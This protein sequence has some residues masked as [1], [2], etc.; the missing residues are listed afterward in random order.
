MPR[1]RRNF[2]YP[3]T[4]V[5]DITAAI[6]KVAAGTTNRFLFVFHAGTNDVCK[7]R[8][9]EMLEKYRRLIQQ[10]KTKSAN[11]IISGVLATISARNM[12]YIYI[13]KP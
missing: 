3:G 2:C 9:E 8:S 7:T 11:I 6:D 5:D 13:I 1:R 4:G 12:L 10:Y